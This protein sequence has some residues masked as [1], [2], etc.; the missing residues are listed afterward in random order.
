MSNIVN[1]NI[2]HSDNYY[3]NIVR[4]KVKKYRL[5]SKMTQQQLADLTGLSMN[6]IS[7]IESKKMQ[8]GF[9]LV[10]IGRIADALKINIK[11]LFDD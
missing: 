1:K 7:K 6:Y 5:K 8:R 11:S 2:Y 4:K 3:F 10:A 9:S